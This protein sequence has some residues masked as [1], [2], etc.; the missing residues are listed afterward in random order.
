[1]KLL[2]LFLLLLYTIQDLAEDLAECMMEGGSYAECYSSIYGGGSGP[3]SSTTTSF[4]FKG[5]CPDDKTKTNAC[6]FPRTVGTGDSQKTEYLIF[7]KCGKGEECDIYNSNGKYICK[8]KEG[9]KKRKNGKS[10]N[11]DEDC[12][13]GTCSSNK[14]SVKKEGEICYSRESGIDEYCEAGLICHGYS[15]TSND[16]KCV[17]PVLTT[18]TKPDRTTECGKGLTEDLDNKC[19]KYGTIADGEKTT[20]G[21]LNKLCKSGLAHRKNGET[22]DIC[23]RIQ[24][25]PKCDKVDGVL[26]ITTA[27]KW[28]KGDDIPVTAAGG[29]CLEAEDYNGNKVY[30]YQYSKLQ[31]KLYEEFLEDYE[32]LDIEDLNTKDKYAYEDDFEDMLKWKTKKKYLLYENAPALQAAKLIDSDG[33]VESDKKCEYEFI[34]KNVLSSSNTKVGFLVLALFA[35]LL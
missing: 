14:C 30:Y 4:I 17:K 2:L 1:M 23:D 16:E 6:Y 8:D 28:E 31:S 19:Q 20:Y 12:L 35:L 33:K 26:K 25:D 18:G 27:G 32:D 9:L 10:C 15:D 7:K 34:M 24:T 13:S 21:G 3:G 29:G 5:K 22:Y 11:Y